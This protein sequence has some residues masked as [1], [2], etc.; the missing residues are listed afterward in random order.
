MAVRDIV[1]RGLNYPFE[2]RREELHPLARLRNEMNEMFDQ[3]WAGER[4]LLEELWGGR[5]AF[6]PIVDVRDERETVEVTA[7]VPGMTEKD[8]DVSLAPSRDAL[9]LK[10]EKRN[11]REEKRGGYYRAERSFGTFHRTIPLPAVVDDKRCE[12]TFKNGVLEV[13][14]AKSSEAE[15]GVKRIPV[16]S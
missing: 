6:G 3:L 12:A 8:I 13:R 16:R 4:P 9:I 15:G 14:L 2:T 11:E 7:E 1:R 5:A 10:G